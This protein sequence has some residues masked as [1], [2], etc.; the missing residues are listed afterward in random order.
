MKRSVFGA[1]A[2]LAVAAAGLQAQER[3]AVNVFHSNQ[4]ANLPT[5][6]TL[7]QG[8][9][10]F[11]ISHRFQPPFSDGADALWGLDGPVTYRLGLSYS[12][13]D[14]IMLGV[15]RTNLEDNLEL[16]A[17]LRIYQGGSAGMPFMVAVAGGTAWN[18]D[19]V[20][21]DG[22]EDNELQAYGLL[23]LNALFAERLALG[24]V[25]G[26]VHNPR[27]LDAETE[28]SF[29]LGLH[30]QVYLT[31]SMSLLGEWLA[32]EER[33]DLEFDGVTFGLEFET[34]GHF[35]KLLAT[36][37]IRPNLTQLLGGSSVEFVPDQ[38]RF[39]FNITRLL[40]F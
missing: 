17:K 34:R 10:L 15:Q 30:G 12:V 38:L 39:G 3:G 6:T 31:D 22:A 36:N 7:R 5:A 27:I 32:S 4:S 23:M 19:P 37:Q 11:E 14:R 18:T 9:W 21:V 28:S 16:S 33:A 13:T 40:P 20:L 24:V 1:A 2:A 35:F 29:V 26:I 25:P 8:D